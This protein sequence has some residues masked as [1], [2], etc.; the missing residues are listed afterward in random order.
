M[1]SSSQIR[2]ARALLGLSQ[3]QLAESL[4]LSTMTV[5]RAE[6]SG[7]PS[8]SKETMALIRAKLEAHGVVFIDANGGGP[9]V[10]LLSTETSHEGDPD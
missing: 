8:A 4:G 2:A 10:R 7:T 1:T 6:G 9:G 3:Q 5:K